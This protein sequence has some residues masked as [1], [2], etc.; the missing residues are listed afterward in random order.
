M[1]V[2]SRCFVSIIVQFGEC[3]TRNLRLAAVEPVNRVDGDDALSVAAANPGNSDAFAPR[4]A[5]KGLELYVGRPRVYPGNAFVA[6]EPPPAYGAENRI[7]GRRSATSARGE[8]PRSRD[9][10]DIDRDW[11][12]RTIEPLREEYR[13]LDRHGRALML[14][15]LVSAFLEIPSELFGSVTDSL[16]LVHVDRV[17]LVVC[18]PGEAFGNNK[19]RVQGRFEHAGREYALWITDP[20]F[21]RTYL[22]KLDGAYEFGECHLTISLG[23]PYGGACHKLIAA[24]IAGDRR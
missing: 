4:Q 18:R 5:P 1:S 15:S 10:S 24:I 20:G 6:R 8:P 19:R 12:G 3:T 9:S 21:E 13:A 16:R 14:V 7:P 11:F 2:A 17:Q 22:A 23:E